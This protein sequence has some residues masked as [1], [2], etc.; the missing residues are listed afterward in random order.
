MF[1]I[2]NLYEQQVCPIF[3]TIFKRLSLAKTTKFCGCVL[4]FISILIS[5]LSPDEVIVMINGIQSGLFSMV[6]DSLFLKELKF[7]KAKRARKACAVGITHLLTK[8]LVLISDYANKWDPLFS[9]LLSLLEC[10]AEDIQEDLADASVG[11]YQVSF[12]KLM[13]SGGHE[14]LDYFSEIDNVKKYAAENLKQFLNI[15]PQFLGNISEVN[16]AHLREYFQVAGL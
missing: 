16:K 14:N 5:K 11:H 12:V 1:F 13:Y 7:I 10:Q 6:L 3:H 8:S 15:N 2:S 9:E 4:V